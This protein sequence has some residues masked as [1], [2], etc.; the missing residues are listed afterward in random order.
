LAKAWS[1]GEDAEVMA[2][3]DVAMIYVFVLSTTMRR[4]KGDPCVA[5][6]SNAII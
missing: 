4:M 1:D 3:A 5:V 2:T 6:A